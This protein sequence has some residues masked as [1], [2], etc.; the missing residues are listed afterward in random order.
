MKKVLVVV[1]PVVATILCLRG[2]SVLIHDRSFTETAQG[3]VDRR[4]QNEIIIRFEEE[5]SSP[6]PQKMEF[7]GSLEKAFPLT[8]QTEHLKVGDKV[9]AYHPVGK[10]NQARL[11]KAASSLEP[12]LTIGFGVALLLAAASMVLV[13]KPAKDPK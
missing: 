8:E 4:E 5:R 1:L 6:A 3:V 11:E 10:L 9:E 12:S 2:I 13:R 7:K